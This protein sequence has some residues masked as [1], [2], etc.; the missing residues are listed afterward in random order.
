MTVFSSP[1]LSPDGKT[2]YAASMDTCVYAID[3]VTGGLVWKLSMNN[4]FQA[5]PPSLRTARASTSATYRAICMRSTRRAVHTWGAS[6]SPTRS[7]PPLS[8]QTAVPSTSAATT[9]E[10]L[11]RT[12]GQR[13]HKVHAIDT[14]SGTEVCSHNRGAGP[15]NASSASSPALS[16]DGSTLYIGSNDNSVYAI[17]T[18]WRPPSP[19][20]PPPPPPAPPSG[21]VCSNTTT[22]NT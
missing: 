5:P 12:R 20:P 2:L 1:R 13:H 18:G 6:P 9:W 17:A 8:P 10:R 4:G 21:N 22:C 7:S 16:P 14:A 19:P 3:V 15:L 11:C